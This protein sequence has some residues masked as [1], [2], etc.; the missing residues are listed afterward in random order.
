MKEVYTQTDITIKLFLDSSDEEEMM[1]YA[2]D[3]TIA[4]FTTNPALMQKAGVREYETFAKKIV[5]RIPD[6]PISFEVFAD[7]FD[8]MERQGRLISSWGGNVYVKIPI[9]NTRGESTREVIQH[10]SADGIKINL[11]LL[12]TAEQLAS[13]I[14]AFQI[15][16]PSFAS[17]FSGR[18][19]DTGRDAL[20]V[21]K[22]MKEII[23]QHTDIELLW[24]STREVYNIIEAQQAGVDI[25]TVPPQILRKLERLGTPLE[26]ASLDGAK[27]FFEASKKAGLTL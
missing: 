26:K 25:I 16:V 3:D 27:S 1:T 13:V 9:T 14:D 8:E 6:K 23:S 11:T 18:I 10:L 15:G 12:F 21:V 19:S 24:A 7:E 2:H 5:A 17:I 4:G 22:D 20:H